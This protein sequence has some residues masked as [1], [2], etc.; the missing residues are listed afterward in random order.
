MKHGKILANGIKDRDSLLSIRLN[1]I[2][3][4]KQYNSHLEIE[5]DS[6]SIV[7]N[8]NIKTIK[9]QEMYIIELKE[10]YRKEKR[11]RNVFLGV[12][13]AITSVLFL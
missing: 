9:K 8:S 12:I 7:I 1:T 2:S 4:L 11:G 5:K 13:I 6:L 10:K 3:L